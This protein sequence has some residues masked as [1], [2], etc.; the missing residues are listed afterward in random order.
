M[1]KQTRQRAP[2]EQVGDAE[3]AEDAEAAPDAEAATRRDG[4]GAGDH[5]RKFDIVTAGGP[6]CIFIR[7]EW[8]SRVR[9]GSKP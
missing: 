3:A 7:G 8:K 4:H 5:V 1:P 2:S 6:L 9:A